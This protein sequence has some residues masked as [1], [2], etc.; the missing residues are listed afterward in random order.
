MYFDLN[1]P[2]PAP[3][4]GSTA[5]TTSKKGKGKQ[6]QQ[7]A[8][9]ASAPAV[10]FSPAQIT[11][12]EARVDLLVHLGYTVIAFTQTVQKKIEQ[13]A[14]VNVLDPLLGQL[15]KRPGIVYL[16]RLTIVLDEDS[17][18]GFGLTN[19][20]APLF[21]PYDLLALLPTTETTFSLACLTHTQPS[22]L[23]THILSIPLTLPRLPFRMKHTL[24][25]AALRSGAVFEIN[26]AGALGL[27]TEDGLGGSAGA[28]GGAKAQLVGRGEGGGEGDEGEGCG[29][30]WGRGER[31]GAEGAEGCGEPVSLV[32]SSRGVRQLELKLWVCRATFLD[33]PQN[34]AHD[35]ST[36]TPKSLVLRA[37]TR[38][39]YRA[40]FSEPKVII[41]QPAITSTPAATEPAPPTVA[42]EPA[43]A[44]DLPPAP[45]ESSPSKKRPRDEE[46]GGAAG[47][48]TANGKQDGSEGSRKKKKK[49]KAKAT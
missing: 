16:K 19:A 30:Q 34:L 2:I 10:I 8:A 46:T 1:V 40:I 39:T 27:G 11:A 14:F 43:P 23:T 17:E 38:R 24:V 36:T 28:G 25:R 6:T 44:A 31:G 20:N 47:S 41:P 3:A 12:I 26:Y 5:P 32:V 18:K 4:S 33:L 42:S 21:A 15:R 29:A 35:A 13:K 22:P 7:Q 49:T 9:P 45:K 48:G 37:Q